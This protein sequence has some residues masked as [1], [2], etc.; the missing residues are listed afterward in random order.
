M[1]INGIN[2]IEVESYD[3]LVN[4]I[5]GKDKRNKIDLR[6]DFIFRG[7]SDTEHELIPS[8]LRKNNLNR[9]LDL[10]K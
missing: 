10:C 2:Q 3:E 5:R 7:L 4:L 6:K 8:S 9:A 1:L